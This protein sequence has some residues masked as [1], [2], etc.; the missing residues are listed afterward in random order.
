MSETQRTIQEIYCDESGF[1]GNNLLD[2]QT[3]YYTYATVAV[4]HEEAKEFVEQVIKDYKV[5]ANELK[6]QKLIKYSRGKKAITHILKNFHERMKVVVHHKKYNLAC[7]FFEY[8]FE[9]TIS[10]KNS[11]F[12]NIDFHR[13]ISNILYLEF[14]QQSKYAEEIFT[15]FYKLMKAKNSEGLDYMF[16]SPSLTETSLF[17]EMIITFCISHR[18]AINKELESL[19]GSGVGKWILDL[20][21]TSLGSLL[22]EWGLKFKNLKVF[23]DTSKPL[24]EQPDFFNRMINYEDKLFMELNGKKHPISFNLATPIEFVDSKKYPGIQIADVASGTFA[25]VF[26]ENEKGSYCQYPEEW[27]EYLIKSVSDYSV[28]PDFEYIDVNQI[29]VQRNF[30]LL[31]ELVYRSVNKIPLLEEIAEFIQLVTYQLYLNHISSL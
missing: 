19:Q 23:C 15:D 27:R 25:F 8:V 11:L 18:D 16:S 31:K 3:F 9:P 28:I 26:Q 7:K 17:I 30:I 2:S 5:Q 20:T 4:S 29:S 13:F 1:T 14:Q 12:Y 24:Q 22:A 6:F 21:L 10:P